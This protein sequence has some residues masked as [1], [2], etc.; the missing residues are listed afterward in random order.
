MALRNNNGISTDTTA[1]PQSIRAETM[2]AR[3]VANL[4]ITR[5][6]YEVQRHQEVVQ[7][8]T[9]SVELLEADAWLKLVR[10]GNM[11]I[12]GLAGPCFR[13]AAQMN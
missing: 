1:I 6:E 4:G 8:R 10:Q 12:K 2:P 13:E 7:R 9:S 11:V 3:M 5:G